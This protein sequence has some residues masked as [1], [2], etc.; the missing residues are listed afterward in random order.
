MEI[1]ALEPIDSKEFMEFYQKLA[2]ENDYIKVTPE[3]MAEKFQKE[4]EK[5]EKKQK[6]KQIFIAL[7]GDEI[8]GYLALKR[9]HFARLRHTAKFELG[10]LEDYQN[11]ENIAEELVKYAQDWAKENKI[12]R[13]EIS[14]LEDD[15][16]LK[17][18]LDDLDFTEE[19]TRKG[20]ILIEDKYHN[21]VIM[22]KKI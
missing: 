10:V 16:N 22:V 4:E 21:E 1:R 14:V 9:I 5:L 8:V 6:I 17:D 13:L 20:T 7:D 12:K 3:E 19:G 15:E 11:E 2:N 18:I